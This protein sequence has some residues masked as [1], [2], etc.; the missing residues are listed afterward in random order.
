[1]GA[2]DT[3]VMD[4]TTVEAAAAAAIEAAEARAWRDLYASAPAEWAA[5]VTPPLT[6]ALALEFVVSSRQPVGV[7]LPTSRPPLSTSSPS[8]PGTG[9]EAIFRP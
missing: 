1:M 9:R 7:G 6:L 5:E 4:A 2:A 8:A 3:T